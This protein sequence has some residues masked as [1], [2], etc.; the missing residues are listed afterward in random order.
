L[1]EYQKQEQNMLEHLNFAKDFAE[2]IKFSGDSLVNKSLLAE[3]QAY[4]MKDLFFCNEL[5]ISKEITPKL[6]T[7]LETVLT[8]L[9]ISKDA[10]DAF[11]YASSDINAQCYSTHNTE[12]VIR[13]SSSLIDILN[14][15]E[16][17]FVVGHE[18]G[19]F[20]LS[21]SLKNSQNRNDSIEFY[22]QQRA[23]EISA[24]RVGLIACNSLDIAIRALIKTISGL[25]DNHLRFDV[26][27]FISQLNKISSSMGQN[28]QSTH[29]S[30]LVRCRA[31]LW[32]SL[33]EAYINNSRDYEESDLLKLDNRIQSD[34]NKYVDGEI[35]K[36]IEEAKKNLSMWSATY[37]IVQKGKFSKQAQRKFSGEFGN[38][39][40]NRMIN[41]LSN[42]ST[43]ETEKV[44]F[45]KV[46]DARNELETLIPSSF[47]SEI[48][49]LNKYL[50]ASQFNY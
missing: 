46:E 48:K 23:Q 18:L 29:P 34:F 47:E 45:S 5:R 21:H 41:F 1:I 24:D 27:S 33:N 17:E 35:R 30:I 37:E 12:C 25:G 11:V 40:L 22:M 14:E 36:Q 20:L 16:F 10:V 44:I 13:F 50:K 3:E 28:H 26:G 43:E 15:E 49:K 39:M 4:S 6:Y 8:R 2:K 7:N 31:L 38:D 9:G 32:F 42:L 19:H